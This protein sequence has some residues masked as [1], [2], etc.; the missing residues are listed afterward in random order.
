MAFVIIF[1]IASTALLLIGNNYFGDY[2][3][4]NVGQW[5]TLELALSTEQ[6]FASGGYVLRAMVDLDV[7]ITRD[8][9]FTGFKDMTV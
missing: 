6:K 1:A 4:V 8:E 3:F 2:S 9:A 5:G 7:K